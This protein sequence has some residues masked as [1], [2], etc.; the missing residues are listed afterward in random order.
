MGERAKVLRRW[1]LAWA[2]HLALA[3]MLAAG[4]VLYGVYAGWVGLRL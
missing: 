1:R 4:V 2:V 3:L